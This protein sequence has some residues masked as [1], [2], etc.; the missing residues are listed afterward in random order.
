MNNGISPEMWEQAW[1]Y[2]KDAPI[3]QCGNGLHPT[4]EQC[5]NCYSGKIFQTEYQGNKLQ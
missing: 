2:F 1:H 4:D 3:I 5:V